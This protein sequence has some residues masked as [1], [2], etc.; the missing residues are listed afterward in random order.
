[1]VTEDEVRHIARL[2][3]VEVADEEIGRMQQHFNEI[4]EHFHSLGKVDLTGI[5]PFDPEEERSC[6]LREDEVK[7]WGGRDAAIAAAP[8][9]E[10]DFFKV[11]RIIGEVENNDA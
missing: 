11:P 6:P 2:I 8:L 3:R 10:D 1:M 4:L 5:D 7:A 9:S